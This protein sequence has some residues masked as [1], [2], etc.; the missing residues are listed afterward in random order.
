MKGTKGKKR[1]KEKKK[2]R[3][4]TKQTTKNN[5]VEKKREKKIKEKNKKQRFAF[6]PSNFTSLVTVALSPLPPLLPYPC[7]YSI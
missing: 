5:M 7:L 6:Q 4:E 2:N 1:E 3:N